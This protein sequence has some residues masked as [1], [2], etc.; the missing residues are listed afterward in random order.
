MSAT[1]QA[2]HIAFWLAGAFVRR[3]MYASDNTAVR[4]SLE[5]LLVDLEA[6]CT[7]TG[8]STF[9]IGALAQGVSL[10]NVPVLAPADALAKLASYMR[11]RGFGVLE[12]GRGATLA[13]LETLI[14]LLNLE[15]ADLAATDVGQWLRDR[16]AAH[17]AVKYLEVAE[18]KVPRAMRELYSIGQDTLS[19][20][21]RRVGATGKIEVNAVK[22]F[23]RTMLDMVVSSDVPIATMVALRDRDDYTYKHSINVSL[24]ASAQASSLG[25]EE[26]LVREIA[27]AGLLHDIGKSMVPEAILQKRMALTASEKTLLAG[28]AQEGARLLLRSHGR[29][30][31]K[32]IVAAEHHLPYTDDPHLASQVVAIADAFDSIRTLC[33]FSDRETLRPALDFMLQKLSHRLNPYLLQRFSTMCGM[34]APGDVVNLT[35][36]EVARVI[37]THPELGSRPVLEVIDAAGGAS[38]AG[39][40]LDLSQPG[41]LLGVRPRAAFQ[42]VTVE[43][44]D[45]LG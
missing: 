45:A 34:Y 33:P 12:I 27:V 10:G 4:E 16:G 41:T 44:I 26:D 5:R 42:G 35:S 2:H 17:I 28:H 32:A 24:L 29:E 43:A 18:V 30:G 38:R 8:A 6:Y 20:Q 25:L 36:G 23:A 19:S 14:A 13:E 39:T 11:Q 9:S 21:L 37:S 15:A 31:L 40:L 3:R 7:E 22:E 1:E